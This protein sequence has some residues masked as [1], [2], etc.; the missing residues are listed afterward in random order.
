MDLKNT[1]LYN[2]YYNLIYKIFFIFYGKIEKGVNDDKKLFTKN[3]ILDIL[4][5]IAIQNVYQY[6]FTYQWEKSKCLLE[7]RLSLKN[8]KLLTVGNLV[9]Y[10]GGAVESF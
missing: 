4:D 2:K 1:N 3:I 9:Y 8:K 10:G 6:T 7:H 5:L